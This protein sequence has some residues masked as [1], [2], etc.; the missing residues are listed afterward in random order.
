[1]RALSPNVSL[2]LGYLESKDGVCPKVRQHFDV[3]RERRRARI[4]DSI[5]PLL[6]IVP[7]ASER[8]ELPWHPSPGVW[9][10]ADAIDR[11]RVFARSE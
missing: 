4:D 5:T 6:G 3:A 9:C 2:N 1:M 10:I 7:A 11:A 8:P